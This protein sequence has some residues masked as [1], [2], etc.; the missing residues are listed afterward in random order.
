[1]GLSGAEGSRSA[2]RAPYESHRYIRD[3]CCVK[4]TDPPEES[5]DPPALHSPPMFEAAELAPAVDDATYDA[6]VPPL[7]EALLAA[8]ADVRARGD[9]PVLVLISGF[10]GAGKGDTL[11]AIHGWMDPRYVR[12]SAFD[13]ADC[14]ETAH[15]AMW[16]FW[17]ALPRAGTTGVFLGA[18]YRE[19]IYGR[20]YRGEKRAELEKRLDEIVRLEKMLTDDGAL[21][22]KLWLH[23]SKN[24][25]RAKLDALES[26][27]RTR[28]RVKP[29]DWRNHGHY[30]EFRAVDETMLQ[31]TSTEEAPW[32]IVGS[33]D[34]NHRRLTV[35]RT[36]LAAM[37]AR[38][39]KPRAP[40]ARAPHIVR[41][42]RETKQLRALD[43]KAS[44]DKAEYEKR[45]A[46]AQSEIA[47]ESRK[48]AK[49]KRSIVLVFEGS[50]A[51]GKGGAIGRVTDALDAR[52]YRVHPVAAP[53]EEEREFP[54]LW[55]FWTKIPRDG[56]IGIFDRSWYG[57]TLVER[58]EG[59]APAAAWKRAYGEINDFERSL[60]AHGAI[61]LKFWLQITKAEQLRRFREREK[62]GYKR[63]KIT[64]E[65]WRNRKKWEAY[66]QAA[67]DT[68]DA[69]ST[70]DA[71]WTIVAAND[72]RLARVTVLETFAARL[73]AI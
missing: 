58:V 29:S 20:V 30:S 31:K 66:E 33:N 39:A 65:D 19:A 49:A 3:L 44:L 69:T 11:R 36:L 9:F 2:N 62:Q 26:S 59:F 6:E 16:R 57:R 72:K 13:E 45:L 68:F 18:W 63:F 71:P 54:Y 22:V 37:Q 40:R 55:R 1:M 43:M 52:H 35:G 7:R 14:I 8:Q 32:V 25:Q 5:F 61:V 70:P 17:R 12:A 24:Q 34:D 42:A 64:A 23:L 47:G 50:D 56:E 4:S 48:A 38:L 53:N 41:V 67:C 73:R 46:R 15:P 60:V 51:A 27:K 28:W 10:E 21:V